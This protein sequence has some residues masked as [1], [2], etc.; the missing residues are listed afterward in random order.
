MILHHEIHALGAVIWAAV[1]K[2]PG[3]TP[4]GRINEISRLA[5]FTASDLHRI[6]SD[7]PVDPA[8]IMQQVHRALRDAED[9]VIRMPTDKVGYYF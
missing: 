9:F 8:A 1:Q 5:R 3:F 2:A 4:D 6:D 7:P